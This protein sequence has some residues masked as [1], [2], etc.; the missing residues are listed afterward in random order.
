MIWRLVNNLLL[1]WLSISADHRVF[2]Q[3]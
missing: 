1:D 3:Q 2:K